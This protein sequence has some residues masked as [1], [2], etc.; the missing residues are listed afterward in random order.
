V[1]ALCYRLT[2]INLVMQ[3]RNYMRHFRSAASKTAPRLSTWHRIAALAVIVCTCYG[4]IEV[5]S[6]SAQD[7]PVATIEFS[8]GS[9]AAG[10][11]YTWG[12]G[13]LI[14]EGKEYPL[15]VDG[16]S[17]VNVGIV[18]YT[19]SGTVYKLTTP[20]DI[21]GVYTAVSAGSAVAGGATA[22]TMQNDK[23]VKIEM[24][25]THTGIKFQLGPSGVTIKLQ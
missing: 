16:L 19:A 1:I 21:N 11:G 17:I 14:F 23:G 3:R 12:S 10:I 22:T 6:A 9:V 5:R 13:T 2:A 7:V 8:G 15:K 20:S 4:L 18:S 25:A 24:V